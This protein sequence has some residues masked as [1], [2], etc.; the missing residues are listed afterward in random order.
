M[1]R[2]QE[3]E[4]LG[5]RAAAMSGQE[6][7]DCGLRAA[8]AQPRIR[9]ATACGT[10]PEDLVAPTQ[11]HGT[12][13]VAVSGAHRG[14]NGIGDNATV[15]QADGLVTATPGLPMTITVADCVPVFL[16]D[17]ERRAAGLVHAGRI[18]TANKIVS[19]AVKALQTLFGTD[20]ARLTALIGPSAGPCCYEVS[21]EM[22]GAFEEAG[23]PRQG[24]YLD[25]WEANRRLLRRAGLPKEN[26]RIDG[27]CTICGGGFHSYRAHQSPQRNMALLM[28]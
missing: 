4:T 6:D 28:L 11:V 20:P 8:T 7:G 3:L 17:P 21:P 9:F 23:L 18:G 27:Q 13:V 5:A 24:Q 2:F 26:I 16:L 10:L 1:L 15:A 25:L 19:V 12:D 14:L 22:A